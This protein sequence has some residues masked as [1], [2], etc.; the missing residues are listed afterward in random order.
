MS[1]H[2]EGRKL[3]PLHGVL[4]LGFSFLFGNLLS[5]LF[6]IFITEGTARTFV[7]YTLPQ[8]GN[9]FAVLVGFK[10]VGVNFFQTL[11]VRRNFKIAPLAATPFLTVSTMMLSMALLYGFTYLTNLMGIGSSVEIPAW[12]NA[13]NVVFG[14]LCLALLPALGEELLFRG[15]LLKSLKPLGS[16]PAIFL[17][18]LLFAV[19]HMSTAQLVHQFILGAILAYIVLKTDNIWYGVII[20]FLNN[21]AAQ[22][23]NLFDGLN[24]YLAVFSW[25]RFLVLLAISAVGAA[26]IALLLIW[27]H[28]SKSGSV[29]LDEQSKRRKTT[30]TENGRTLTLVQSKKTD[31]IASYPLV[32]GEKPTGT[33]IAAIVGAVAVYVIIWILMAVTV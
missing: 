6:A 29:S 24:R 18:A 12:N 32:K 2:N 10:I 23:L 26:F 33:D 1:T 30:K 25:E 15:A 5:F 17:S 21:V 20:H 27:I 22:I 11:P 8:V 28:K 31:A 13:V 3:T 16:V 19:Q 4:I 7:M 14:I 9:V